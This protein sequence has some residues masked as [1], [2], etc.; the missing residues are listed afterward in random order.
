MVVAP[1]T[2]LLPDLKCGVIGASDLHWL[3]E[4]E[5]DRVDSELATQFPVIFLQSRRP[6]K[7]EV[8]RA[9]SRHGNTFRHCVLLT[10]EAGRITTLARMTSLRVRPPGGTRNHYEIKVGAGYSLYRD[11]DGWKVKLLEERTTSLPKSLIEKRGWKL[12]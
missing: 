7:W 3:E 8:G 9:Q 5:S 11:P 10:S 2:T 1:S 6:G 12:G 4:F